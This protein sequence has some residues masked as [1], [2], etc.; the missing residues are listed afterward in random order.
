M[1]RRPARLVIIG[2][3][4]DGKSS[5]ANR[6]ATALG[7][8]NEPLFHESSTA[9]SNCDPPKAHEIAG[10]VILD[11]PGLMDTRGV[12]HDEVNIRCIVDRLRECGY[13][14]GYLLV[15]NEQAP[16]FDDGMQNAVKLF[17]DSLGNDFMNNFGIVFTR[18]YGGKSL[19]QSRRITHEVVEIISR[20]TGV[21]ICADKIPSWQID[22]HPEEQANLGVPA[23]IIARRKSST[24]EAIGNILG[25][26]SSQQPL[27]TLHAVYGEYEQMA[28]RREAQRVAAEKEQVAQKEREQAEKERARADRAS[29]DASEARKQLDTVVNEN[30]GLKNLA[31]GVAAA[32]VVAGVVAAV[33]T[34]PASGTAAVAGVGTRLLIGAVLL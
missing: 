24:A 21:K 15:I 34:A 2:R 22:C 31:K 26:T 16:R 10:V 6:L 13:V 29:K 17:V 19:A 32:A 30:R 4:G 20:K 3:T 27:S 1:I 11:T 25:W 28:K 5:V 23:S 33:A 14:H 8:K 7:H 9:H 18:A 12:E